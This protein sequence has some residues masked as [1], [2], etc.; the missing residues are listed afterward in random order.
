[1]SDTTIYPTAFE[2]HRGCIIVPLLVFNWS[3]ESQDNQIII[4]EKSDASKKGIIVR[5]HIICVDYG[6]LPIGCFFTLDGLVIEVVISD[7]LLK[8]QNKTKEQLFLQLKE[9]KNSL[10]VLS[11]E[12]I[13]FSWSNIPTLNQRIPVAR[14]KK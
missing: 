1:M 4:S 14:G 3:I 6:R 7:E 5:T 2:D 11:D 12:E 10:S 13:S 9:V 8:H